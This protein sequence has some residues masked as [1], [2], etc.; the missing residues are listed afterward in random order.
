VTPDPLTDL[1]RRITRLEAWTDARLVT[2][3]VFDVWAQSMLARLDKSEENET[4]LMRFVVAAL[5]GVIVNAVVVAVSYV[6]R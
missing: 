4:W 5:V 1:E 6:G 3:D 2:K